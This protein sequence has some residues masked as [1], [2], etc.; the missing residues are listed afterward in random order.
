MLPLIFCE[1]GEKGKKKARLLFLLENEG[2]KK[3]RTTLPHD[4]KP[5]EAERECPP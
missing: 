1:R 3:P 5:G 4:G 2:M